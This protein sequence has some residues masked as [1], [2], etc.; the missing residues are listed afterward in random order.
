MA[1]RTVA[2]PLYTTRK[3]PAVRQCAARSCAVPRIGGTNEAPNLCGSRN[4]SHFLGGHLERF[5]GSLRLVARLAHQTSLYRPRDITELRPGPAE[6]F[7]RCTVF[8]VVSCY[9]YLAK[10]ASR[11]TEFKITTDTIFV[12]AR[13]KNHCLKSQ[14][15]FTV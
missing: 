12:P 11:P 3:P 1:M 14:P 9:R 6:H 13:L 10:S 8:L 5:R 15:R 2:V 4:S 7:N